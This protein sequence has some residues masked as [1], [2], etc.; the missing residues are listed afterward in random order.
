MRA[1]KVERKTKETEITLEL[2]LDG[3]GKSDVETP[4]KFLDHMLE[5]FSKHSGFDLK[6]KAEGDVE[7]D[8][9]HLVEDIGIVLGEAFLK[10]LGDKKGI[11]RMSHSIVPMDD[12]KAEVSVDLS[13]RP[14]AVVELPFSEFEERKVGDVSKENIEHLLESFA[15]NGRFN[16]NV[17]VEGKNDHHKVEATFKALAKALK[18]SAAVVGDGIPSTKGKL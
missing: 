8:D 3:K 10:A 7:V 5:S 14:Y 17:K 2:N 9:H 13:G 1:A 4:L 11:A 6:V 15:L 18:E 12:S 16:L